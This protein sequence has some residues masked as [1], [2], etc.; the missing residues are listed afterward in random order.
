MSNDCPCGGSAIDWKNGDAFGTKCDKCD[1]VISECA[2]Y[3]EEG[4]VTVHRTASIGVSSS[5][6]LNS[7]H[8]DVVDPVNCDRRF[9]PMV[10]PFDPADKKAVNCW[11][12]QYGRVI[13]LEGDFMECL[14][15]SSRTA[16]FTVRPCDTCDSF[17]K[18]EEIKS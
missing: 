16:V 18:F 3:P 17:K 4:V 11:C 12:C 15:D 7:S 1:S 2:P 6:I 10:K 13:G 14:Q 9:L 8:K 5:F